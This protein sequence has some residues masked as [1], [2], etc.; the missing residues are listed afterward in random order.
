MSCLDVMYHQSYGSHYLAATPAA[1][2]AA[3]KAAYY[4]HHHHHQQQQKLSAYSKMQECVEQQSF[5]RQ[6]A[7]R[8]AGEQGVRRGLEGPGA[9]AGTGSGDGAGAGPGKDSHPPEYLSS[10]CVLF[11]YFHGDIGDVV[12]EHFSRALSQPSAFSGETKPTRTHT[13]PAS[14]SIWKD[15]LSLS[16]GQCSSFPSSVWS[17][18]YPSQP[19]PCLPSVSVSIHPDFSPSPATFHAPDG[20]LWAGPALSQ[21][22]LPPQASLPDAWSYSLSPQTSASYPHVHEVY[23]HPHQHPHSHPHTHVHSRHPHPMLHSHPGHGPALDP[24]FSPLLLPGVRPQSHSSAHSPGSHSSP[25]GGALKTELDPSSPSPAPAPS[26]WPS[27]LHGAL[28]VY[29][30]VVEQDKV[31]GSIWF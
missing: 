21:A 1:A 19:S 27:T 12:D 20:A 18:S 2:A 6:R 29:D 17:T 7:S 25:H 15:G 8:T 31:K 13:A 11:T 4:Q 26:T 16:D 30:S 3:Y 28:D 9:E 10:R 22:S 24:R 23:P 5:E 14:A